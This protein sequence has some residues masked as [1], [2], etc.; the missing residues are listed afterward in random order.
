MGLRFRKSITIVPGVRVNLGLKGASLSVGTRGASLNLSS[1]GVYGN[2]GI[3]GTGIS[4]RTQLNSQSTKAIRSSSVAEAPANIQLSITE[5]GAV[6]VFD[7][8]DQRLPTRFV[9]EAERIDPEGFQDFLIQHKDQINELVQKLTDLVLSV[10]EPRYRPTP[11][12]RPFP[13]S[14]PEKQENPV[15]LP[16][17]PT[18]PQH[19]ESSWLDSVIPFSHAR[20]RERFE[21]DQAAYLQATEEYQRLMD[22]YNSEQNRIDQQYQADMTRYLAAQRE[23]EAQ[24]HELQD[25]REQSLREDTNTMYAV[26]EDAVQEIDWPRETLIAFNFSSC[27]KHLFIDVDLPEI[28][29]ISAREATFDGSRLRIKKLS[30]TRQRNLYA[31]HVGSIGLL[32]CGIGF[33]RLPSIRQIVVSG[34]SQRKDSRTGYTREEY[35]YSCKMSRRAFSQINFSGL[36]DLN[37]IETLALGELRC[38][39]SKTSLFKP[40]EPFSEISTFAEQ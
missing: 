32:L 4:Y 35:L 33:N 29:D 38:D 8:N 28:E 7:E 37:P 34:F 22:Q 10:P 17:P 40:I 26:F 24:T 12:Y 6:E 16:K 9:K 19:P 20:K 27:G 39:I 21:R 2:V 36:A 25:Q 30:A 11:L 5:A 15:V 13:Q 23:H 3:P 18:E 1:R 31:H 14:V